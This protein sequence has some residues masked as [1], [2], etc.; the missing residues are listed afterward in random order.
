MIAVSARAKAKTR[1]VSAGGASI[2][3]NAGSSGTLKLALNSAGK[4]RSGA[5][6]G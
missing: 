1:V 4:T 6:T 3:I 2:T 5:F